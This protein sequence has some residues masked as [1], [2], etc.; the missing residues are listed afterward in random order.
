MHNSSKNS[1]AL[2]RQ[3]RNS[4]QTDQYTCETQNKPK[5]ILNQIKKESD[6]FELLNELPSMTDKING[7]MSSKKI[8]NLPRIKQNQII[9]LLIVMMLL[10]LLSMLPYRVFSIWAGLATKNDLNK[11]GK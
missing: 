4:S 7:K 6:N 11:L 9:T 5:L 1:S 3:K 2:L 8:V 10:M